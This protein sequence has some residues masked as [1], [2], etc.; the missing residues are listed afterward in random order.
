M[1]D[2]CQRFLGKGR[3]EVEVGDMA[4]R[5]THKEKA[6]MFRAEMM[7]GQKEEMGQLGKVRRRS[8]QIG[9]TQR[10][11]GLVR[12]VRRE[13]VRNRSGPKKKLRRKHLPWLQ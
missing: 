1:E 13:G 4:G 10:S 12:E 11:A 3:T 2:V 9:V 7:L 5:S 8:K 6:S